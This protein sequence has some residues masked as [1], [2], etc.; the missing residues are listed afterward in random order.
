VNLKE[1]QQDE[2][3]MIEISD[4]EKQKYIQW[5]QTLNIADLDIQKIITAFTHPSYKGMVPNVEDYERF[6]FLGDAVL[7]LISAEELVTNFQL[8]EGAMTEKRKQMVNNEYLSQVF[9][10]LKIQP[11]IRTALNYTPSIKDKANFVE[12]LFGAYY[13]DKKYDACKV[14]WDFIQTRMGINKKKVKAAPISQEE[15]Q[16]KEAMVN[17]YKELGLT[18]KNAKSML[19]ELCQKQNLDLPTYEQVE[20]SGPDHDPVFRVK[21]SAKLFNRPPSWTYSAI[22]AGKSKKIAE[23]KAAEELCKQIFLDY[24]SSE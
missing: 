14:L 4:I 19:Q 23:I 16:N 18:P 15:K 7:E 12:A 5:L 9:D 1:N 13:L 6:E 8:S 24:I 2:N 22:G 11:L 20:R 21:I 17:Y 3:E 10:R